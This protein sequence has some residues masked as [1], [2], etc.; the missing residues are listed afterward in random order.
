MPV[1]CSSY[2]KHLGIYLDENLNL[3]LIILKKTFQKQTKV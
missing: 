3:I 2:R 1:A